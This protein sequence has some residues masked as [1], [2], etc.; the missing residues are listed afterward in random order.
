LQA[1]EAGQHQVEDHQVR[2][3][4]A[5]ALTDVV[6]T[7][8]HTDVVAVAFQVAGNQLGEC[9]VVFHQEDVGHGV[10]K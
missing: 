8:E 7:A 1:V 2:G 9:G 5:R 3:V 10:S 6:A 4:E